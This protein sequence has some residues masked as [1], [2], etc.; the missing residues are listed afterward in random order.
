MHTTLQGSTGA[1]SRTCASGTGSL[2]RLN[3]AKGW[4]SIGVTTRSAGSLPGPST[5]P[6]ETSP[7]AVAK[8]AMRTVRPFTWETPRLPGSPG[9]RLRAVAGVQELR[10][11]LLGGLAVEGVPVLSLGSRKARAVLRRLAVA[12]GGYVSVDDLVLAAWPDDPPLRAPEQLAVLVSRLRGVVGA[13]R[14]ERHPAGYAL[15]PD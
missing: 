8:R 15:H 14:L 6:K 11:R 1:R 12:A 3:G 4:P 10:V 13:E 7:P 5:T 2:P 9:A